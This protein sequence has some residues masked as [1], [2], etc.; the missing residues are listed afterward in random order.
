MVNVVVGPASLEYIGG[1]YGTLDAF[2][3]GT[4]LPGAEDHPVGP[5][6]GT[7]VPVLTGGRLAVGI[8]LDPGLLGTGAV[9]LPLA[10]PVYTF[11]LLTVQKASLKASGLF[12]TYSLQVAALLEHVASVDHTCPAQS[13]QNVVSN[14]IC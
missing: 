5:T 4:A 3:V 10:P 7:P 12:W 6:G 9:P 14:T 1:T 13:P 11:R 8:A 2:P